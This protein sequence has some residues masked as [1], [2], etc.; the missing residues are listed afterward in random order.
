M[1]L[2]SGPTFVAQSIRMSFSGGLPW[3]WKCSHACQN[4]LALSFVPVADA[5]DN[6]V[7]S[8]PP[9]LT[10]INDYWEDNYVGRQR[11]NRRG[12]PRFPISLW[13][14]HNHLNDSVPHTNNS[15][16]AWHQSFQQT[17]DC[18]YPSVYKLVDDFRKEQDPVEIM[19]ERYRAGFRQPEAS[20]SKYVRLNR[21]LL[22]LVPTY[23][24]VPVLDYLRGIAH[25][26]AIW[27]AKNI[28]NIN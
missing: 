19:I 16:E 8:S 14:M 7:E 4:A 23:V 3:W 9:Q 20:K 6:L 15:V 26:V 11:R 24:N 22:A 13:N 18:H 21:R 5:F 25:N 28:T 10:P 1:L 17:V 27:N 2:P 12:N